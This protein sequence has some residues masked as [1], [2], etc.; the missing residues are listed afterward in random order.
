MI[1]GLAALNFLSALSLIQTAED[2]HQIS[3]TVVEVGEDLEIKSQFVNIA[4]ENLPTMIF[5]T[6]WL[7]MNQLMWAVKQH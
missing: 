7:R 6:D 4:K 1:G 5:M 2:S 3:L